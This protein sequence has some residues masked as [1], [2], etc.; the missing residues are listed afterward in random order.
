MFVFFVKM[1]S[2]PVV[3]VKI[4]P[5]LILDNILLLNIYYDANLSEMWRVIG[6][7]G[8]IVIYDENLECIIF[9]GGLRLPPQSAGSTASFTVKH[10]LHFIWA[11]ETRS[12]SCV[13]PPGPGKG[14]LF[15]NCLTTHGAVQVNMGTADTSNCHE[16]CSLFCNIPLSNLC[17]C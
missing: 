14:F 13:K 15:C 4:W 9:G 2:D 12:G 7:I 17:S 1:F 5:I 11:V 6:E 3:A 16:L 10:H 8:S